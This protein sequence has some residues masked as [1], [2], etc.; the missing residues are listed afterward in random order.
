VAALLEVPGLVDDQHRA[1]VSQVLQQ[2]V[3][4]VVAD[5]ILIPD[6]PGQQV[7]Q[8]VGGGLAG[9]LGDRPA[10]L[11]GQVGQQPEDQRPGVPSRLHPAEPAGDPTQ[12]LI[13]PRLPAGRGYAVACGHR[14][15]FGCPHTTGSSPVAALVCR[16]AQVIRPPLTSKVTISGWSIRLPEWSQG[17]SAVVLGSMPCA[18]ASGNTGFCAAVESARALPA[19]E[20]SEGP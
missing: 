6:R 17:P 11:S 20:G 8:A 9:V 2:P 10:V 12:Q 7:L 4:D 14:V 18:V 16:P 5:G 3:A 1:R 13:Q 19:V 15:I